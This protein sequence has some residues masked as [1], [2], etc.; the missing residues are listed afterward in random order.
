MD[1]RNIENIYPLSPM[2]QGM[3][4]HSLMAPS[5]GVYIEQNSATLR[6]DLDIPAFAGAWQNLLDRHTILR[7]AFLWE[8]LDEPLQLVYRKL[9]MPLRSYDWSELPAVDQ[10]DKLVALKQDERAIGFDLADAP[11]MRVWLIKTGEA[12][13]QLVWT[14]HH[15]LFDGWS[16]PVL[17]QELFTLYE[18]IS[19]GL[20]PRLRYG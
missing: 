13:H 20:P 7:T 18:M 5:S 8:D 9:E 4:Y 2:Q 19:R 1:T 3:L 10:S 12:E 16:F 6:G 14:F 17:L 15:L 11:L